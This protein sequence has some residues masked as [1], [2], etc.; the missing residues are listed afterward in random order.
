[1]DEKKRAAGSE[2][3]PAGWGNK[4]SQESIPEIVEEEIGIS[5]EGRSSLSS[6]DVEKLL[7]LRKFLRSK[8]PDI[9]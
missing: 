7:Q 1:M 3:L 9:A 5:K 6:K 2:R 8:D 4:I